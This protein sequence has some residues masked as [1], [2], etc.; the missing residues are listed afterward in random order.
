MKQELKRRAEEGTKD[1]VTEDDEV[2]DGVVKLSDM[3]DDLHTFARTG[4]HAHVT[5]EANFSK[6]L[7]S[8]QAKQLT[9]RRQKEGEE[10]DQAIP[11]PTS[12]QPDTTAIAAIS[13]RLTA[14]ESALGLPS[15]DPTTNSSSTPI[16]PTLTFLL[17]Q[18]TTLATTLAP[19][20][21]ATTT[22]NSGNPS[23][24]A[25]IETLR[26]RIQTLTHE[27]DKL[28]T[29]R[30]AATEAAISLSEARLRIPDSHTTP[31]G[32]KS[33]RPS[34]PPDQH[35]H[36]HANEPDAQLLL[37][38]QTS[39]INA[40]YATL[41]TIQ[42]L[43]PL[44]PSVLD[45]LR[46]LSGIHAGAG[47]ARADLDEVD[48]RQKE[49]WSEIERWRVGLEGVEKVVQ[50]AEDVMRGNVEVIGAMVRGVEEKLVKLER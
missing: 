46:S 3:L 44:L 45:R 18:I 27:T 30:K 48:R 25:H 16:L 12:F 36:H 11:L 32:G 6:R 26:Q 42:S 49:V 43:H 28:T 21:P 10:A 15:L 20:S 7:A 41:P 24:T 17:S 9:T 14:L 39:K 40:L 35:H 19:P 23:S 31:Y 8:D 47:R 33:G 34:T 29:S 2:A 1:D 13:D 38:E 22:S 4:A 5:A 50:E 37:D